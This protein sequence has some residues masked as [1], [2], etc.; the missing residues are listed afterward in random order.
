VV[1]VPSA[2][3]LLQCL[4]QPERPF[5]TG[6][7]LGVADERT[8]RVADEIASL[9]RLSPNSSVLL[10]ERATLAALR[11]RA[12]SAD[13]IHLACHGQFRPDNPL[14]S[15]LK[16]GHGWLTV[17]DVYELDLRGALVTLSACETGISAVVPGDELIGLV[18]GFFAAGARALLVSLWTVGDTA[19]AELMAGVYTRLQAGDTPATALRCAQLRQMQTR[20]HPY[21]WSP[22]ALL[23]RW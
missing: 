11:A 14:F 2:R 9:E 13:V 10:D 3:V 8:P 21:F 16:L 22:F 19:T 23:G 7:L 4:A 15:A 5:G 20:P 6:L 17:R 12:S 18:R 1:S